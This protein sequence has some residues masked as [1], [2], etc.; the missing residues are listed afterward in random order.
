VEGKRK[1]ERE[2]KKNQENRKGPKTKTKR[3]PR[4]EIE[5]FEMGKRG[6]VKEGREGGLSPANEKRTRP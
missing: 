2:E 1:G 6:G 4:L 5:G 3:V